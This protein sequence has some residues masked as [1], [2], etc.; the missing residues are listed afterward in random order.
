MLIDILIYYL[1]H[2]VPLMHSNNPISI[3]ILDDDAFMLKLLVR[4]LTNQGLSIVSTY[5]KGFDALAH[6]KHSG[7]PDVIFLDLNMPEM[8]GIEFIRNLVDYRY[9]GHVVLV[10]GEDLRVLQTAET[11]VKAHHI[12]L[13]GHLVKP[14]HPDM[15]PL[16]LEKLFATVSPTVR[17]I[18]KA[19]YD[20]H[21]VRTAI[22]N[23]ELINYYQPKVAVAS[24]RVIGVETL[25]R[26][27]HPDDGIVYPDQFISVAE[28][29]GLIDSLT[30]TV[31]LM[32]LQQARTW[33]E[34]GLTLQIAINISM[35][36]LTSLTF[37][38]FVAQHAAAA[39]V[40]PHNIILEITESRL[41]KDARFSLEVLTRLRLKRFRLSIDDFGTGHSSFTQLRNIPFDELKI[42][43]S[44]VHRAYKNDTLRAIYDA[45]L[46]LA[47]QLGLETVAEGVEDVNDWEFLRQTD[48]EFA[49]GYFIAHPMP[50]DAL[51]TWLD[52]WDK[53]LS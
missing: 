21:R 30:Q 33:Q 49:Q 28:E 15:L 26:W 2:H 16:L 20:T 24:G 53:R 43:R 46:G 36:N 51:L 32:A 14:F 39:G 6:L 4:M 34:A 23:K 48:C 22:D 13:L 12:N 40:E 19:L 11:L 3:L 50:G 42:D 27:R 41:M 45:S 9:T 31:I 17:C 29:H 25:V 44:F 18:P 37:P 38:D 7:H 52:N 47:K 8:D 10:S 5:H 35:D 1:V